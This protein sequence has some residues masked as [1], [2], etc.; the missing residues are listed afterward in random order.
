MDSFIKNYIFKALE[1]INITLLILLPM[2]Y[3]VTIA[4]QNKK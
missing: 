1:D 4:Q 2:I 3:Q